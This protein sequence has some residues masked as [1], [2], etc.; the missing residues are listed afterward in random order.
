MSV[1][2]V[3]SSPIEDHITAPTSDPKGTTSAANEVTCGKSSD[4]CS[5]VK[6]VHCVRYTYWPTRVTTLK[7]SIVTIAN[8]PQ[9]FGLEH[10]KNSGAK[11]RRYVIWVQGGGK[12]FA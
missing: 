2:G 6:R 10:Q 5:S 1:L 11:V 4:S 7:C 9:Q 12:R 8:L 3:I